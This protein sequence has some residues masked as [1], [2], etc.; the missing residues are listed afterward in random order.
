[1]RTRAIFLD[2]DGTYAHHGVV[3][4]GHVTSVRA[5]RAAGHKVFLCTGRPASALPESLTGAGFDGYVCGAGAYAV[6]GTDVLLDVRFPADLARST[7]DVL[8]SHGTFAIYEAPESVYVQAGSP[9]R[10]AQAVE[11]FGVD[12]TS[13]ATQIA[14]REVEDLTSIT[15]AKV[16]CI[17]G[18][19][20]VEEMARLIGPR[21]SVVPT[22]VPNLGPGAYS[23]EVYQASVNKSVG[24]KHVLDALGKT[25]ADA[26]AFGDGINDLEMLEF[27][28]T[29]VAIE[30]SDPRVLAAAD[31]TARGPQHE[32]LAAAFEEL[33]LIGSSLPEGSSRIGR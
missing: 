7:I 27:A 11:A 22:S 14:I 23:G 18:D 16:I 8:T 24:M 4:P 25:A 6:L 28:G 3:P 33:G 21:V 9:E 15:F 17:G 29:A 32:G 5:A 19:V 1:M 2:V 31:R 10:T 30:G 13:T 12:P 20:P 26:V